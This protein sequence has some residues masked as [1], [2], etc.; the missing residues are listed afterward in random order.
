MRKLILLN[1]Y[2]FLFW[3]AA[4]SLSNFDLVFFR[5]LKSISNLIV[6]L[7]LAG[8]N[9]TALIQLFNP[10]QFSKIEILSIASALALIIPPLLVTLEYSFLNYLSPN[11]PFINS[12]AIFILLLI[13]W[14]KRKDANL[15]NFDFL[16]LKIDKTSVLKFI[17]SPFFWAFI[18]LS[19]TTIT[20]FST[21]YALPD[22]DP[23]YWMSLFGEQFKKGELTALFSS[24]PLFSSLAYIFNQSSRVDLYAYFKY[25]IPILYIL[26]LLPAWMVAEK[27]DSRIKK[28][29]ILL[30][31]LTSASTI[32][33][34]QTAMPQALIIILSFYFFFFI[35][36][37]WINE[38]ETFYYLAG[39]TIFLA[40]FYQELAAIILLPWII[41]SIFYERTAIKKWVLENNLSS[42]LILTIIIFY[43]KFLIQPFAFIYSWIQTISNVFELKLNIFFPSV[44][45]NIDGNAMGWG[46]SLGVTKY[47][48]YYIGFGLILIFLF[49]AYL[50]KKN[51]SFKNFIKEEMRKK[52]IQ[53]IISCF[54][55]FFSISEIF[56][57]FFNLA[58]LPERSW[59][60]GGI[61]SLIFV[62]F[63]LIFLKNKYKLICYALILAF[64]VNAAGA[65]Y[66]NGFKK[67]VITSEQLESAEW[68]R[69]N[70]S[71]K[72]ILFSNGNKNLISFYSGSKMQIVSDDFYYD[73]D[74]YSAKIKE[75]TGSTIDKNKSYKSYL[76][77]EKSNI[78]IL[79]GKNIFSNKES[80]LEILNEISNE[81]D[82]IK[83][84]IN[85][86][87]HQPEDKQTLYIYYAKEN[88]KNPYL[89]RPYYK[90]KNIN[91]NF[92]FDQYLEKFQRIYSDK[93]EEIIIWKI[94]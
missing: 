81:T 4:L 17:K 67:Y 14:Q 25:I 37:S 50:M 24:R 76:D 13:I 45:S 22:L 87:N 77:M 26:V 92:I 32:L 21:F 34:S 42:V 30:L 63:I 84:T 74:S 82:S 58:L 15:E 90:N 94:L 39:A 62:I 86:T 59:I 31:P 57:R 12:L 54:I 44:Y 19:T 79:E 83:K 53:I 29:L 71:E 2:A 65:I 16:D 91:K 64:S 56:P 33:Y 61:F 27:F 73:M 69:A 36:Y 28:F 1:L 78:E 85:E 66:I 7:V 40:Y 75:Y 5:Y 3:I 38:N 80:A 9:L 43:S 18:V 72:R 48:I 46:K 52:E 68:I 11:L 49:F 6:I 20:T 70:L 23:Y 55:I 88:E 51:K 89:N 41:I 60:F 8:L 93:E 47:Y 35:V 10:K